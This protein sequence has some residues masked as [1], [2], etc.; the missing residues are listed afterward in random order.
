MSDYVTHKSEALK[1]LL[2][3]VF[4]KYYLHFVSTPPSPGGREEDEILSDDE[5]FEAMHKFDGGEP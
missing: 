4:E 2:D 1:S 5:W 3:Q